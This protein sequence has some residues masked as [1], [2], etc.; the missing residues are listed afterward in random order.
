MSEIRYLNLDHVLPKTSEILEKRSA[1]ELRCRITDLTWKYYFVHRSTELFKKRYE[2]EAI[3]RNRHNIEQITVDLMDCYYYFEVFLFQSKSYMDLLAQI[4]P[5]FI[6]FKGT[7]PKRSFNK[8][9]HWIIHKSPTD[10]SC[11]IVDFIKN[12]THWFNILQTYRDMLAHKQ[13][14]HPQVGYNDDGTLRLDLCLIDLPEHYYL[15]LDKIINTIDDGIN[16]L[17][18]FSDEIF[19]ECLQMTEDDK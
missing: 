19:S 1:I 12:E 6:N 11:K 16:K 5:R 10:F 9:R 13:G 2:I 17:T 4:Y 3:N 7:I 8:F 14:F 15:S 18:E